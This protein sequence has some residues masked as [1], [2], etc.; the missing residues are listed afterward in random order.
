MME[1]IERKTLSKVPFIVGLEEIVSRSIE[2]PSVIKLNTP[3]LGKLVRP[4]FSAENIV[5]GG[6]REDDSRANRA[7]DELAVLSGDG[8]RDGRVEEGHGAA[9]KG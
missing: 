5:G 2:I 6:C 3:Q 9:R 7:S 8:I 4:L 1:Y